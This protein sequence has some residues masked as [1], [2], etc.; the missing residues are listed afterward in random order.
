MSAG[1]HQRVKCAR[2][3][4]VLGPHFF[5]LGGFAQ[6]HGFQHPGGVFIARVQRVEASEGPLAAGA[7]DRLQCPVSAA[8][9]KNFRLRSARHRRGPIDFLPGEISRVIKRTRIAEIVRRPHAP[10][11]LHALAI[12]QK[13]G[14]RLWCIRA[15]K[16]LCHARTSSGRQLQRELLAFG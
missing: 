7:I 6:Q 1:N 5:E 15:V 12:M 2:A 4:E 10:L 16:C 8:S 14:R 13:L 11:Y 9:R 3:P